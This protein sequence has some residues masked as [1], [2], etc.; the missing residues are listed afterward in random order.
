MTGTPPTRLVAFL[1]LIRRQRPRFATIYDHGYTHWTM[2]IQ[3]CNAEWLR[4]ECAVGRI[5]RTQHAQHVLVTELCEV[6]VAPAPAFQ[7]GEE[8][9]VI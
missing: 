4:D 2:A 8:V 9:R 7:L 6:C 5:I 1:V 3:Q